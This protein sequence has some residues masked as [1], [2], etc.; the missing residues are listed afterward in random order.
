ME[1]ELHDR[2]AVF[3]L[4]HVEFLELVLEQVR[5]EDFHDEQVVR[6][7]ELDGAVP[8]EGLVQTEDNG[9]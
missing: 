7:L 5:N 1:V 8:A 3:S 4:V 9:R 6:K 2:G